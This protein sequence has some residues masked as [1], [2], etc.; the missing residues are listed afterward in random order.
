MRFKIIQNCIIILIV[1]LNFSSC[2]EQ[3]EIKSHLKEID[4]N[5]KDKI[6]INKFEI[7]GFTYFEEEV[8]FKVSDQDK[9]TIINSIQ[10]TIDFNK[11]HSTK[12]YSSNSF[13][14][15]SVSDSAYKLTVRIPKDNTFLQHELQLFYKSNVVKY[16]YMKD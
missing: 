12:S 3:S 11:I 15:A 13:K 8:E 1:V 7:H 14:S 6:I 4:I 5:L 16:I 2:T 9:K 10:N